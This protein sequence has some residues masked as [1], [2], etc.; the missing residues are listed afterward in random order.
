MSEKGF[1]VLT[2]ELSHETNTFNVIRT[3]VANFEQEV[4]LQGRDEILQARR[5]TRSGMGG[6][7]ESSDEYGWKLSV[8]LV[9]SANPTGA[10][11]TACFDDLVAKLLEPAG[12]GVRVDGV[13]LLL[14]GA[15]VTEHHED[16]EGEILQR[17]RDALGPAVPVVCTLDLHGNVT[18]LMANLSNCLIACRTY[19]HVD[20]YEMAKKGAML[21]QQAM[22]S[23]VRP[24][25][26]IAKRPMLHGLDRGRTF[27][28]SPMQTLINRAEALEMTN[29]EILCVSICAGFPAA[30]IHQVGPSVTVTVDLSACGGTDEHGI[31][32]RAQAV[33]EDLMD[34][35]WQQRNY[36]SVVLLSP[37]EAVAQAAAFQRGGG[38]SGDS[39]KNG[40]SSSSNSG[41]GGSGSGGAY[42]SGI[43]DVSTSEGDAI[44]LAETTDNPGSGHYGDATNLLRALIRGTTTHGLHN[45]VFYSIYDPEA[46]RQCLGIGLGG[47]GWVEVGGR[48]GIGGAPL[49]L[50]GR[51]VV[52]SDGRFRAFGPVC[53]GCW[54]NMGDSICF[55]LSTE[56][57]RQDAYR[58][59]PGVRVSDIDTGS[60][61]GFDLCIV[62]N[63]QQA[64][65]QAQLVNLGIDPR[66]KAV[67]A[68]KSMNHFKAD[69]G[70]LARRIVAVDGGGLGSVIAGLAGSAVDTGI[71]YRKCR[72]P[73]WP[74]DPEGD[75][76]K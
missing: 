65:D 41:G 68:L 43:D 19:P 56:Y 12:A 2:G 60:F 58:V 33:A 73:I 27:P 44:I 67:L 3:E 25:Q 24:A 37:D 23:Q 35:C 54:Q 64:L 47:C 13:L 8:N 10:L 72:R 29:S 53:G 20:F 5:G 66:R 71:A 69:F 7:I 17:L 16:A 59:G 32:S 52:L 75:V 14:H 76:L 18:P 34:Y 40:E 9:A 42:S 49:L 4:Y 57:D 62:S 70:P 50:Y 31:L 63:K 46:V 21:L 38:R 15:M 28:G 51:V 61:T 74:L 11:T 39:G 26:V 55:R 30:D 6:V 22:Q 48:F 1:A 45:I 36:N